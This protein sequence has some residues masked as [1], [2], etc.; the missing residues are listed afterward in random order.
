[1][2]EKYKKAIFISA[3]IVLLSTL[4]IV[5]AC[6]FFFRENKNLPTKEIKVILTY[7]A[8]DGGYIVGDSKQV[9][10]NGSIGKTV[11]ACANE[12]YSFI[13]WSDGI[14]ASERSDVAFNDNLSVTAIFDKQ[15]F[16]LQYLIAN[17]GTISGN[18]NQ[19]VKFGELGTTVTAVADIGYKFRGWSDG[20]LSA[21]RQDKVSAN[22]AI[23]ACFERQSFIVKYKVTDG[24]E[25][26]SGN[27]VQEVYYGLN[28]SYVQVAPISD[29]YV[30]VGWSDGNPASLRCDNNVMHSFEVTAIF[31]KV[32]KGDGTQDNPFTISN[33]E[34]LLNI[35]NPSWANCY[36][37]LV[38]DIDMRGINHV[39]FF[40]I[41]NKM[42]VKL[43]GN[44]HTISNINVTCKSSFPSLFGYIDTEGIVEN[45]NI[46]NASIILYGN[47]EKQTPI[48]AG[49]VSG[50]SF[51][52]IRNVN[53]SGTITSNNL[54]HTAT[55]GGLTGESHNNLNACLADIAIELINSNPSSLN[56]GGIAGITT[57]NV[58]Q[59]SSYGTIRYSHKI[60][61]SYIGYAGGL[62]GAICNNDENSQITITDST[63]AVYICGDNSYCGGFIGFADNNSVC[64]ISDCHASGDVI[65]IYGAGGFIGSFTA[66][67]IILSDC[68][69]SGNVNSL[70]Y[71][72]GF[73][74]DINSTEPANIQ[75]CYSSGNVSS[76]FTACG[77]CINSDNID[78][79][80]CYTLGN[81]TCAE[82][83]AGFC[84]DL[85]QGSIQESFTAGNITGS[86]FIAG[87]IIENTGTVKNCYSSSNIFATTQSD[88]I[89]G[90]I[91][92][93]N[94]II[95]NCY[96]SGKI[97]GNSEITYNDVGGF[98]NLVKSNSAII[99]CYWFYYN[100]GIATDGIGDSSFNADI[101]EIHKLVN[102]PD[103]FSLANHLN[104][105][106]NPVWK[107][108][109]NNPPKLTF[110]EKH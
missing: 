66:P 22:I 97:S 85:A 40:D 100:D 90:F 15:T 76:A 68:F 77:F 84:M 78:F 2:I 30:F 92:Y 13:K 99:N 58:S 16:S 4:V 93:A 19:Q 89:G 50:V 61:D 42:Q 82:Y 102:L 64:T 87:F 69:S 21:T 79:Y 101:S 81:V 57:H 20:I 107:N 65:G 37:K 43:N 23:T 75:N 88:I 95:E 25:I 3:F 94:A 56:I 1:M 44:G 52:V 80:R 36:F 54:S 28:T 35:K 98:I 39:P 48:Y 73:A 29:L 32:G 59:C 91:V 27:S 72:G 24:G 83:A 70:E 5:F 103:L 67:K 10:Q 7:S 45:L 106:S 96:F 63:S 38:Q 14:T 8:T 60:K 17:G 12:G 51:G 9:L 62:I 71:A 26:K 55:I 74:T 109:S 33:Y 41:S 108:V 6:L 110:F 11:T 18:N 86:E 105:S 49:I 47:T 31:K 104:N 53:V 34:E 46:S